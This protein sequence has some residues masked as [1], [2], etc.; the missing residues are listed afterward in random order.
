VRFDTVPGFLAGLVL[1]AAPQPTPRARP[2][3][4][5]L[6]SE[7]DGLVRENFWD[8]PLKGID[9]T[10]AVEKAAEELSR[11][12][13]AS[14]RDA[15]YDRLLALLDDS[16]TFRLP[17]G[18]LPERDWGTTGL[19][20]GREGRGFAV[21]GLLPGASAERA[22]MRIGDRV[23]AVAGRRYGPERVDF[24]DLFLRLEGAPGSS[25]EVRW[26]P[27]KGGA[28]R[29]SR[30]ALSP[31]PPGDA[32]VWRSARVIRRAGKAYGYAR[33]W[34]MSSETALALVDLLRDREQIAKIKPELA[35]WAGIEGFLLDVRANSGGYDPDILTTF[36]RGRWSSGDY[37][38]RTREGRMLVPPA[39]ASLSVALLVNSATA[40]AAEVLALKFRRHGIGP[41]VGEPTAGM[42]SAGAFER[43]LSDGSSL[44]ISTGE[45]EDEKGISYE[46]RS[47]PPDV[48]VSDLPAAA[49]GGEDAVVE[50][51][52]KALAAA[53]E[54]PDVRR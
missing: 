14:G 11:A 49:D 13:A 42:A 24:R 21:K 15:V 54:A 35:G 31:E 3:V 25:V 44:W 18:A 30:L 46:G 16:H 27:A 20:I 6:L 47:V 34:G 45:V 8:P 41:I 43:K 40:S 53:R 50:A 22:G 28:E 5:P 7:I 4:P 29:T 10:A 36:L 9:W 32:L 33:L 23:L 17:A 26:T 51:G 37:Y 12:Q 52:L 39:Y 38:R 1:L 2:Q 19:R 48:A